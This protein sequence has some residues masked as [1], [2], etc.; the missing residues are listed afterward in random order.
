[1]LTGQ[2]L[3]HKVRGRTGEKGG[4]EDYMT[5]GCTSIR[6]FFPPLARE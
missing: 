3:L 5:H 4:S 1:M 2:G 6:C